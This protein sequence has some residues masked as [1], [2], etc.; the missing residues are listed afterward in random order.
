MKS[1]SKYTITALQN[2]SIESAE[3]A[4]KKWDLPNVAT[5]GDPESLAKDPNVD[6]VVVC[7]NVLQHYKLAKPAIEAGKDVFVEWPLGK[8]LA[9]A[10]ELLQLAQDKGVKTMV[11]LQARYNPSI[12]KAREIVKSGKLGKIKETTM[13]GHGGIYAAQIPLSYEYICPIENGANLLT[14]PFSHS[15]D[16]L[17]YVLGEFK[18]LTATLANRRPEHSIVNAGG[19]ELRKTTK[20]SHDVVSMTATLIEGGGILNATYVGDVSRTGRNFYWEINGT[21]GSLVLE[22]ESG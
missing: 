12:V 21:E 22:A 13:Y 9:E 10:E 15:I 6:I 18:D 3:A 7:V 2:S 11:G 19:K 16:G 14:I 8:N 20:T 1:S 17:A 5:H 4:A